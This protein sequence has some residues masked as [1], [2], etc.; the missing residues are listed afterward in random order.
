MYALSH[1]VLPENPTS[2][3]IERVKA[4]AEIGSEQPNALFE[5]SSSM[6]LDGVQHVAIAGPS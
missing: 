3:G 5:S 4:S 2:G 1:L 6:N